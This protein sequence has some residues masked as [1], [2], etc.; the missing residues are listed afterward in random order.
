MSAAADR[1]SRRALAPE[2]SAHPTRKSGESA[3]IPV[4]TLE[5][6]LMTSE[7]SASNRLPNVKSDK[8]SDRFVRLSVN[9]SLETAD[10]L[11]SLINR[12][13][14]SI[15]EGIRRAI[16]VWK[17]VEDETSRGNEIAV[18]EPD[19]SVRKVILL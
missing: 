11:K 18:I 3:T 10:V 16:A 19:N 4:E 5:T 13:G 6:S 1:L 12:K 2:R 15:T 14:L 7:S 9:L 8:N 17:F